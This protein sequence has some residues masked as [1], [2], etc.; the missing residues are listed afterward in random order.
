MLCLTT[1]T[2]STLHEPN[3]I[4]GD[5]VHVLWPIHNGTLAYTGFT[6]LPPTVA[7]APGHG[8]GRGTSALP[9]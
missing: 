9:R 7:W 2:A 1:G 3:G 8:D 6:V 4:D 5:I